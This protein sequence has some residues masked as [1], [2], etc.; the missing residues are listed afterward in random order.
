MVVQPI[1]RCLRK[2]R[3]FATENDSIV[4]VSSSVKN[5]S[6][7]GR[8]KLISSGFLGYLLSLRRGE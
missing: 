8:R 6:K 7:A 2:P 3:N 5:S 4:A 1:A